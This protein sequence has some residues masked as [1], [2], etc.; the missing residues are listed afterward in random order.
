MSPCDTRAFSEKPEHR[1]GRITDPIICHPLLATSEKP[2]RS[3]L[4]EWHIW[5]TDEL[6]CKN[7]ELDVNRNHTWNKILKRSAV[8][9]GLTFARRRPT[10]QLSWCALDAPF[11]FPAMRREGPSGNNLKSINSSPLK[12][13][14]FKRVVWVFRVLVMEL[15]SSLTDL[16]ASSLWERAG[17][18]DVN[19]FLSLSVCLCLIGRTKTHK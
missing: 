17:V 19:L 13:P 11:F 18:K 4:T 10:V 9:C 6:C 16:A 7:K 8:V 1:R 12:S 2:S 14:G 3:H 5:S 15:L